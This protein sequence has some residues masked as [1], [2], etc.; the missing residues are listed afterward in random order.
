LAI[1]DPKRT[2]AANRQVYPVLG[3]IRD[4]AKDAQIFEVRKS[5]ELWS[6]VD[7]VAKIDEII[8]PPTARWPY[9]N[10]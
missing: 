6:L 8:P 4:L 7:V 9:K 5:D 10:A 2:A 3:F 1:I